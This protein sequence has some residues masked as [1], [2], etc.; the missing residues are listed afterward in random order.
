MTAP[1]VH[2]V[3]GWWALCMHGEEAG[4]SDFISNL[5]SPGG[6]R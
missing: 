2:A 5:I 4:K 3:V 6:K 1:P